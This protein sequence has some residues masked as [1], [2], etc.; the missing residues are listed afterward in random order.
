M[1]DVAERFTGVDATGG[2]VDK[3][4]RATQAVHSSFEG[5]TGTEGGLLKK[6]H[7]L[8]ARERAAKIGGTLLEHGRQVE[9]R[10]NLMSGEVVRG[11]QV[12]GRRLRVGTGCS[13]TFNRL[14]SHRHVLRV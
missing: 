1:R 14:S 8:L 7:H 13:G 5:E 12:A 2:L 4:S 9:E 3:K 11:D 10:M 6:H